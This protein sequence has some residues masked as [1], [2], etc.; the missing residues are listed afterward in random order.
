VIQEMAKGQPIVIQGRGSQFILKDFP[1][2]FHILVV[3]P[4]VVR[5]RSVM[6]ALKIGEKAA[7][8]EIKRFDNGSRAFVKRYFHAEVEDPVYYDLVINTNHLGVEA[9]ASIV[10]NALSLKG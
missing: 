4:L 6:E 8:D 7:R 10:V 9:A 2:A 1:D 5:V 3:A